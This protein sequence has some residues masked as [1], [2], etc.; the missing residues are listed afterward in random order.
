MDEQLKKNGLRCVLT[1]TQPNRIAENPVQVAKEHQVFGCRYIGIGSAPDG[2]CSKEDV[3]RFV[4]RF[5]PAAKA[6]REQG[7]LLMYHNHGAEFGK[8]QGVTFM[9]MMT[10]AFAC[11][12]LGITLDTYWVQYG[13]LNPAKLIEKLGKRAMAIHFKDFGVE[14]QEN[15]ELTAYN[16]RC[17]AQS[18]AVVEHIAFYRA[19]KSE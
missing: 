14:I 17:I 3:Q 15:S 4:E 16:T 5:M 7:A 13:G 1:H 2:M 19:M 8:E 10:D 9:E 6:L 11:D 12:E 18:A